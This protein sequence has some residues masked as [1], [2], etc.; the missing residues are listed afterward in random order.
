ME[1]KLIQIIVNS[2]YNM[3]VQPVNAEA[4]DFPALMF[5]ELIDLMICYKKPI[6]FK[7]RNNDNFMLDPKYLK[8]NSLDFVR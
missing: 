7:D 1:T 3:V 6:I 4:Y 8:K 2:Q 5:Q